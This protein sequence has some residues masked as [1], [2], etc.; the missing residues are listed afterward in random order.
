MYTPSP[1]AA[2]I[3]LGVLGIGVILAYLLL[4]RTRSYL[5]Y[6]G[7]AFLLMGM[8]VMIA[9]RPLRVTFLLLALASF[10]VAIIDS[11]SDTRERIRRYREE[12]RRREESYS[13]LLHATAKKQRLI[14]D[15]AGKGQKPAE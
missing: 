3:T 15:L 7:V 4:G 8:T 6:L 10:V 9:A 13:E 1:I 14:D 2:F 12:L 11:I 5:L